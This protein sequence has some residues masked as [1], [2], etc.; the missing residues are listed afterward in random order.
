M[1]LQQGSVV[2][3][4]ITEEGISGGPAGEEG[5]Q[6]PSI[7]QHKPPEQLDVVDARE[8]G[9][10]HAAATHSPCCGMHHSGWVL[11]ARTGMPVSD[12]MLWHG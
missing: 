12:P 2:S 11:T 8:V 7:W 5:P 3:Q 10:V 9:D 6:D 1:Y 4:D